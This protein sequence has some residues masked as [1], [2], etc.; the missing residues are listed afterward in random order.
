[1]KVLDD[2]LQRVE[3]RDVELVVHDVLDSF[4]DD[5]LVDDDL[6]GNFDCVGD[7]DDVVPDGMVDVLVEQGLENVL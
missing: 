1:V 3:H 6:P 4:D 7:L 5:R 2:K